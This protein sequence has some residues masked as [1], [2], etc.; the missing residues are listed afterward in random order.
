LVRLCRTIRVTSGTAGPT[1]SDVMLPSVQAF[2]SGVVDYA[3]LF[4]PAKLPLDEAVRNYARYRDEA[5]SWML[6]RFVI[7]AARLTELDPFAE[8]FEPDEPW[9]F[10]AL[11]RGGDTAEEFLAGLR[12]DVEAIRNFRERYRGRVAVGALELRLP[13]KVTDDK[14]LASLTEAAVRIAGQLN[15]EPDEGPRAPSVATFFEVA[16]GADWDSRIIPVVNCAARWHP[17]GLKVRCGGLDASAVPPAE[18]LAFAIR[19][20][21]NRGVPMKLTAGL[22][23]PFRHFDA[24]LRAARGFVNVFGAAV[25]DH[26]P[27][28]TEDQLREV[29]E[30]EDPAH[31][32]FTDNGFRWKDR[33][34]TVEEIARARGWLI[35]SFGSC[36]FDEPR[37][38]LR[39][40]RWLP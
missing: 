32:R 28:L 11:G 3:G 26:G 40:L 24:G 18:Q 34:A 17:N 31:F 30:D 36:S 39:A 21:R 37:D 13:A 35:T 16:A 33:F 4:P 19:A 5:E 2:L 14:E 7:P 38:D 10:S 20:C 12:A 1:R 29:I 6:G 8:L 15:P 22:H 27:G 25:L 9:D 23:H